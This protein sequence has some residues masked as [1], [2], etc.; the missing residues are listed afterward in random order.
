MGFWAGIK[1]NDA[2]DAFVCGISGWNVVHDKS[3]QDMQALI[4]LDTR[5]MIH[6]LYNTSTTCL[7]TRLCQYTIISFSFQHTCLSAVN[8]T[9]S[10]G[11]LYSLA[12]RIHVLRCC[13]SKLQ[14]SMTTFNC[15]S[16]KR[17]QCRSQFL[18]DP[19]SSWLTRLQFYPNHLM[20][21]W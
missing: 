4:S 8:T 17:R 5:W 1:I 15:W 12:I 21:T 2:S 11:T 6:S 14:R 9:Q 18:R 3:I 13:S 19:K 7:W 20:S 10:T 16:R